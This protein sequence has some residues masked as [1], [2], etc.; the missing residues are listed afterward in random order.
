MNNR[1]LSVTD[2]PSAQQL[3]VLGV[4]SVLII[5]TEVNQGLGKIG[6]L[7]IS[8]TLVGIALVAVGLITSDYLGISS[9]V[10][11]TTLVFG[12]YLRFI[13]AYNL[14]FFRPSSLSA[15]YSFCL[16]L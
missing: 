6:I 11:I 8:E 3:V 9:A 12:G 10:G 5:V 2:I 1:E 14:D 15:V 16:R 7:A 13:T 4:L